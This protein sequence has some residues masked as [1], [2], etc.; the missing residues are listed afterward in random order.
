MIS[1]SYRPLILC[2][3]RISENVTTDINKLSVSP[4]NFQS[5]LDYLSESRKFVTLE[6]MVLAPLPN[7]VA[8]TF[9]DGYRDNCKIAANI[10]TD[11]N[12]S[13]TF[14]LATRFIERSV[15]YYPSTFN[16][17][18]D[19][20]IKEKSIPENVLGS[21]I[22]KLL[23]EEANY[24]RALNKLSSN[25]PEI[26]WELSMILDISQRNLGPVDELERP[27]SVSEVASLV[28]SDLF[29]IGPHT[30]THPRMSSIP[31]EEAISD[32]AESIATVA[33]WGGS[34]TM[35]F[36][37]PFGQKSDF[38]ALLEAEINSSM[39]FRGLSTF[40]IAISPRNT[41]A[42]TLPRLSVQ[43]WEIDKF[44][45]IVNMAN[46]FSYAPMA[47][48]FALKASAGIRKLKDL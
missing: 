30:A 45:F 14:F 6:E 38:N 42:L 20:H 11:L 24:F 18:W 32:F 13:A 36:P 27:M 26:L 15:N 43:N 39:N 40:P 17:L 37:Y 3:H 19:F 8:I 41:Y 21:P 35:Y 12:I 23:L 28:S 47:A 29:S 5:Q 9:D 33:K 25:R 16:A 46:A 1:R 10:L 31:S 7:T 44:R 34:K 2:Y 4:K 48:I 22:E